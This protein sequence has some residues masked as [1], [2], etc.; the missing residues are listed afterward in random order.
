MSAVWLHFCIKKR[1]SFDGIAAALWDIDSQPLCY[2]SPV[3]E[4]V[5]CDL[6][7]ASVEKVMTEKISMFR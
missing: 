2:L 4:T 5:L 6:T 7:P 3:H 1:I